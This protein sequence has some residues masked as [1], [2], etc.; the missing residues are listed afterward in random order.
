MIVHLQW[1]GHDERGP[2]FGADGQGIAA[3]HQRLQAR[4]ECALQRLAHE[5]VLVRLEVAGASACGVLA[6]RGQIQNVGIA[7]DKIFKHAGQLWRPLGILYFIDQIRERQNLPLADQLLVEVGVEELNL[8]TDR[9]RHFGLLDALRVGQLPLAELQYL[10]VIERQGQHADKQHRTQH[11][12][13][14]ARSVKHERLDVFEVH[15]QADP[16]L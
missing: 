16:T 7:G 10:A 8:F 14:D 5:G 4:C 6:H 3:K 2:A 13:Q 1:H 12:P 9:S 11:N 15:G